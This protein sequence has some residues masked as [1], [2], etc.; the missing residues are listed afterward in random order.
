MLHHI[1]TLV[2]AVDEHEPDKLPFYLGGG[3]LAAWAVILGFIGLR[4]DDFPGNAVAARGV[5]GIS[6]V[7]VTIAIVTALI[8]S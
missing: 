1:A 5:M 4:G 6:A 8:T 7:L 2:L 3:A